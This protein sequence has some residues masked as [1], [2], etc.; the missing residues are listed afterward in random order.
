MRG[1]SEP[2]MHELSNDSDGRTH[3]HYYPTSQLI[4]LFYEHSPLVAG[5]EH[6]IVA[7]LYFFCFSI[8]YTG[9]RILRVYLLPSLRMSLFTPL[10]FTSLLRH[11]SVTLINRRFFHHHRLLIQNTLFVVHTSH[12]V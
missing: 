6:G 3:G 4:F 11:S 1:A 7:S 8:W 12:I 5:H 10:V 2:D 9:V